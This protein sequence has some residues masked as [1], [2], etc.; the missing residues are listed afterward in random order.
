MV[1]DSAQHQEMEHVLMTPSLREA[2][3]LSLRQGDGTVLIGV[4]CHESPS[5]AGPTVT[6]STVRALLAERSRNR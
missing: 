3:Q 1:V 5:H 4:Q 2:G 6:L